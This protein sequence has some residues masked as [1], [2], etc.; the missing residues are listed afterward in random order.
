MRLFLIIFTTLIIFFPSLYAKEIN[1]EI[2]KLQTENLKEIAFISYGNSLEKAGFFKGKE[3]FKPYGISSF[4][5]NGDYFYLADNVNMMLKTGLLKTGKI[6]KEISVKT[7][8]TDII[9]SSNNLF[10]VSNGT[11]LKNSGSNWIVTDKNIGFHTFYSNTLF[12]F[13]IK[14]KKSLEKSSS[15]VTVRKKSFKQAL[16]NMENNSFKINF[17]DRDLG[18]MIY[19]GK[20]NNNLYHF[21]LEFLISQSPV[22][23][24]RY[25]IKTDAEGDILKAAKLPVSDIYIPIKD[26]FVDE[27]GTFWMINP[28]ANGIQ[29]L[30]GGTL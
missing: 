15:S 29:L 18:A 16:V 26:L 10:V 5:V 11:L 23:V 28:T 24:E 30:S 4:S 17:K 6:V 21:N 3:D 1:L 7:P 27:N 20:D 8:V 12:N 9:S 13:S 19:L 2:S 14:S 25:W 22:K